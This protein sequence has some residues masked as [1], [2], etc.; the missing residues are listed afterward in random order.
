MEIES[1]PMDSREGS[2]TAPAASSSTQSQPD[3]QVDPIHQTPSGS[4]K[5][6]GPRIAYVLFTDIVDFSKR[7]TEDQTECIEKF[8]EIVSSTAEFQRAHAEGQLISRSTGDGMALVFFES[9]LA[10]VQCA[11]E[12]SKALR[13]C[14]D[15]GLRMGVYSGP[16]VVRHD[17][18]KQKDATGDG[19]N[20]AQ[21]V[22]DTGDGGHILMS[23]TVADYLMPSGKW[24]ERLHDLGE[25]E[26]KHKRV[27]HLYSL[28]DNEVGNPRLPAKLTKARQ[29]K[30]MIAGAASFVA[31]FL[32]AAILLYFFVW[33]RAQLAGF[34]PP[35]NSVAILPFVTLSTDPAMQLVCDEIPAHIIIKLGNLS[36]LKV[37]DRQ[38]AALFKQPQEQTDLQH[39]GSKL[40]VRAVLT[41]RFVQ[42]QGQTS[43][44][45]E[46][47]DVKDRRHLWGDDFVYRDADPLLPSRI[48][49]EVS[50]KLALKVT[51]DEQA[52]LEK[53]Y[54]NS[55]A[56]LNY[57]YEASKRLNS[58]GNETELNESIEYFKRAIGEDPNFAVAYARLA[59]AYALLTFYGKRKPKDT[60]D[61][62]M[63]NARKAIELDNQLA[64]AHT[65]LGRNKAFYEWDWAGA[66]KEFTQALNLR[67]SYAAAHHLYG[68]FL[69]SQGRFDEGRAQMEQ[70]LNLDPF[71]TVISADLGGE[72][73]FYARRYDESIA[74]LEKTIKQDAKGTWYPR[75]LLG[76]AY[77]QSGRL[78]EAVEV[79]KA[80]RGG[81]KPDEVRPA[82][83]AMLAYSYALSGNKDEARKII[84]ELKRLSA[85]RYIAPY[86]LATIYVGLGE[87]E[88]AIRQLR[89]ARDDRFMGMVWLKVNPRFD[90]LRNEPGF[91]ELMSEM[92]F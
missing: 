89:T 60:Y 45:V 21:R 52:R 85:D 90:S 62:S 48:A 11:I 67:P 61:D 2:E 30:F 72:A 92:K 50:K 10:P 87:K 76:W 8:Q 75:Y 58:R 37:T 43:L 68:E 39:I 59:D 91:Q 5:P 27:V 15:I 46:L 78:P 12:I 42:Q 74:Q 34:A 40:N 53:P 41:G 4:T 14:P 22:M 31:L 19:I 47:V 17:V 49:T 77:A 69:I 81:T 86:Y 82:P 24:A 57:Y 9:Y 18:S 63:K 38:S 25:V 20:M 64:E 1:D 3:P 16:L 32:V 65:T 33:R 13:Q 54:T 28:H 55:P 6:E 73:L 88:E 23:K 56:A 79:L 70:A 29:K 7:S 84:E 51:N 44:Q 36:D 35:V 80:A 26:V 66:E 71:S 83:A